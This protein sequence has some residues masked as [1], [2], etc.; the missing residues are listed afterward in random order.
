MCGDKS[1]L[2]FWVSPKIS[3]LGVQYL[4]S[5]DL[6]TW[7]SWVEYPT[8]QFKL[9]EREGKIAATLN[10]NTFSVTN[11]NGCHGNSQSSM[12][13][14]ICF[15]VSA[16]LVSTLSQPPFSHNR[17]FYPIYLLLHLPYIKHGW[18]LITIM[19][20]LFQFCSLYNYL[21][22]HVQFQ[23]KSFVLSSSSAKQHSSHCN[24]KYKEWNLN[25]A[26]WTYIS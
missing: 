2:I 18:K 25:Y 21:E 5:C 26:N 6:S 3:F 17:G 9:T 16:V 1:S 19:Q 11:N 15:Q 7:S 12:N 4:H 10:C 22:R 13:V 23:N 20:K 24:P 14:R 8:A